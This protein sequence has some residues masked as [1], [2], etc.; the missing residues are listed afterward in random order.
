M[1]PPRIKKAISKWENSNRVMIGGVTINI[2]PQAHH[3]IFFMHQY[4]IGESAM[5]TIKSLKNHRWKA[6]GSM[7]R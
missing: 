4:K 3:P 1:V 6:A 7:R 2:I 5:K